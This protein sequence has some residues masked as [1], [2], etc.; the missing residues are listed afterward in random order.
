MLYANAN[1]HDGLY[2]LNLKPDN[3]T[4]YNI[5]TKKLKSNDLNMTYL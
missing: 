5:N 3:G 1:L 4:I 2:V